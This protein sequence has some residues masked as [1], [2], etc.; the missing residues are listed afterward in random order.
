MHGLTNKQ[1]LEGHRLANPVLDPV[2]E[3]HPE[4]YHEAL[5]WKM[6]NIKYIHQW[7]RIYIACKHIFGCTFNWMLN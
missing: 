2:V 5:Q 7:K 3:F 1:H 6:G 4:F